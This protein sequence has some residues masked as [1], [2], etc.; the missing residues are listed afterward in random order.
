[1]ASP[2]FSAAANA[3]PVSGWSDIC[4]AVTTP[5]IPPGSV[6]CTFP[7]VSSTR[8]TT[9]PDSMTVPGGGAPTSLRSP[10]PPPPVS[11]SAS[12]PPPLPH[13]T[14]RQVLRRTRH[15]MPCDSINQGSKC[16]SKT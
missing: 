4:A 1:M 13:I 9:A 3:A 7:V 14:A 15:G 10:T 16:V 8:F 5:G 11:A 2:G 12:P 6:T